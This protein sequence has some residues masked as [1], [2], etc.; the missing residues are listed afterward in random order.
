M[1]PLVDS[2]A[3]CSR[4]AILVDR[5]I[6]N[7]SRGVFAIVE[8]QGKIRSD[9]KY[10]EITPDATA[11]ASRTMQFRSQTHGRFTENTALREKI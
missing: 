3:L 7:L 11:V 1:T 6:L 2:S 9:F 4:L 8:L 10:R 5:L